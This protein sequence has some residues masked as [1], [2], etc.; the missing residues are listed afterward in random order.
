[1]TP[2]APALL[3][4]SRVCQALASYRYNFQDEITLQDGIALV[5]EKCNL[6]CEYSRD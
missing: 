1:M 5:L 3:D 2:L 4:I 6:D